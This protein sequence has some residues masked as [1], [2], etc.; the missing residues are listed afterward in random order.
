MMLM[1]RNDYKGMLV[2]FLASLLLG[3][4]TG[5]LLLAIK[6]DSDRC[7]Y[8]GGRWNV[9]DLLRGCVA[10]GAGAAVRWVLMRFCFWFDLLDF[11]N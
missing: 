1:E 10:I 5:V 8:Y 4:G 7:H 2:Y 6:E 11:L 9:G 3:C